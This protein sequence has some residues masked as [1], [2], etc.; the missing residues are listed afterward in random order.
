MSHSSLLL[1]II[2]FWNTRKSLTHSSINKCESSCTTDPHASPKH[3]TSAAVFWGRRCTSIIIIFRW[4]SPYSFK[5]L[6]PKQFDYR[7]PKL[8]SLIEI[9]FGRRKMT[10]FMPNSEERISMRNV[11]VKTTL[12]QIVVNRLGRFTLGWR[13]SSMMPVIHHAALDLTNFPC[14]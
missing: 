4:S 11:A 10:W 7:L 13:W 6:W 8:L 2:D 1:F 9:G 5:T 12:V 14:S 3:K